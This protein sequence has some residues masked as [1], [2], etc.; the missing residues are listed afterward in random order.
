MKNEEVILRR[1]LILNFNRKI[2]N[3]HKSEFNN[4]FGCTRTA[5]SKKK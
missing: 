4:L 3:V 2:I 5:V 1:K